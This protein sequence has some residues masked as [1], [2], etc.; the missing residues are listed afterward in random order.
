MTDL[1][2]F[3]SQSPQLKTK[4][5]PE[6]YRMRL[7]GDIVLSV[8]LVDVVL[9]EVLSCHVGRLLQTHDVED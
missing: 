4:A 9:D 6:H 2:L 8:L 3:E 7:L 5:H 1:G